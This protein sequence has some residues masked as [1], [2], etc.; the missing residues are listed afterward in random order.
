MMGT[1][2]TLSVDAPESQAIP[3][4]ADAFAEIA[5]LEDVLSEWRPE[6][7][8]SK[9]NDAA[10]D[11]P[12]EVDSDTLRVVQAGLEVSTWSDGAF[13]LTWAALRG[14]YDFHRDQGTP[15]SPADLRR[16]LPLIGYR[17]VVVDAAAQTVF[18]RRAGMALGTG[19]IGKGYALDRAG[20]ILREHGIQSYML[21]AG[22]QV[23]VAGLRG[24]R[25]W[26]VGIQH[27][28]RTGDYFAFLESRGGSV[29]TS[30]DYERFFVDATGKRYHHIIDPKTGYPAERSISVTLLSDVGLY[31]DA[32]ATAVFVM[33]PERGLAMLAG[34]P[35][36]AEAVI[37]DPRCHLAATP[38]TLERLV[39]RTPLEGGALPGCE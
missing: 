28:R 32:L 26:R 23:Q 2:Y 7:A 18:L 9:V 25:P 16:A 24:D 22:G 39:F 6:S 27:P 20:A 38:T 35:F 12:V 19:A 30:G 10:G 34:L 8:I 1:I 29:A 13:D 14:L 33:G 36:H 11:H 15:P 21:N 31:A 5:R 3:A 4:L 37:V 17:D